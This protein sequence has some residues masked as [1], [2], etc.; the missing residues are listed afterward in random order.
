MKKTALHLACLLFST[1]IITQA[2]SQ[3]SSLNGTWIPISQE[4]NGKAFPKEAFQNQKLVLTDS[5]YIVY[6]EGLDKGTVKYQGNKLDIYGK[7]GVNFGKH[8][9]AVY[10]LKRGKL[11]I[12]YDLSGSSYP[13]NF[14]TAG[15][16]NYFLS[17]FKRG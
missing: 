2:R 6:A 14:E 7:E 10:K 17:V 8:F 5:S 9:T 3:Q 1:M 13:E 4:L 15:K 16:P 11:T 12:C